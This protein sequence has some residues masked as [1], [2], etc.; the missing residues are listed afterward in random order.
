MSSK[1]LKPPIA[2]KP[3]RIPVEIG[4]MENASETK[5]KITKEHR[6]NVDGFMAGL[7]EVAAEITVPGFLY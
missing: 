4:S 7:P 6:E 1:Y 2:D 5:C 3:K